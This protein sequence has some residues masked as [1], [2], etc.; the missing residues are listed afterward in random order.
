MKL[1][2]K[3]F[4][5]RENVKCSC[6]RETTI[7]IETNESGKKVIKKTELFM[8]CVK[9]ECSAYTTTGF[10]YRPTN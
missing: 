3:P 10:C 7:V 2:A 1:K 6:R 8:P 5:E 4:N 9:E